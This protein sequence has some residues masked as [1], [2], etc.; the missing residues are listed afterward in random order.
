MSAPT[1]D[2]LRDRVA[3]DPLFGHRLLFS[4]GPHLVQEAPFHEELL[5]LYHSDHE[6]VVALAF[7]GGGKSTLAERCLLV[8][9][10]TKQFS[11]GVIVCA[12]VDRA[13]DRLRSIKAKVENADLVSEI[14]DNQVGSP[15]QETRVVL[16]NGVCLDAVGARQSTRGLKYLASRPDFVLIDDLEEMSRDLDNVSTPERRTEISEWFYGVLI[17]ALARRHK[18]RLCGTMLHEE[19]LIG[20]ASRSPDWQSLKVPIEYLDRNGDRA[21]AW[22][23]MF[24]L[25][26][27]DRERAHCERAGQLETFEREY[28]CVAAAPQSRAFREEHFRFEGRQHTWEPVFVLYDPARTVG[29]KSD[30]TGKVVASV[31][32]GKILVWEASANHWQPSELIDDIFAIN[33]KYH[34]IAI[35]VEVTG[36][37]Q[38]IEQPLRQAQ[39]T[40]GSL[41]LRPMNPPRGPGKEGFLLRLQPFFQAGEVIFMGPRQ[42]FEPLIKELLGFPYGHDDVLNALAY[43]LEIKPGEAIYPS[44]MSGHVIDVMPPGHQPRSQTSSPRQRWKAHGRYLD[45]DLPGSNICPLRLV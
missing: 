21:A 2:D 10:M 20:L 45:R 14:F 36:L 25:E 17:P 40:R 32:G 33:E 15:W 12:T 28:M 24:D 41:P 9:A 18:I 35:G 5:R 13:V 8:G 29:V 31:I 37:N 11:Y 1:I 39:L 44:F 30:A 7:R 4:D 26:W 19:S 22:P 34:P 42:K 43:V 27:I 3:S 38:F 16:A 6:R 23:D